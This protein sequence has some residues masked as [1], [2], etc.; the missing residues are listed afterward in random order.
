[1]NDLLDI[2]YIL[3][4][5]SLIAIGYL[6]LSI[7]IS[8]KEGVEGNINRRVKDTLITLS[9]SGCVILLVSLS[10]LLHAIFHIQQTEFLLITSIITLCI[11]I[12][13][14]N[15]RIILNLWREGHRPKFRKELVDCAFYIALLWI[16]FERLNIDIVS[17]SIPIVV[18]IVI[19]FYVII[20]TN[21]YARMVNL[22]VFPV[23]VYNFVTSFGIFTILS[24]IYSYRA[25]NR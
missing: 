24:G 23:S 11:V 25:C 19:L 13:Y 21:R 10:G 9:F 7:L 3:S 4:G 6:N 1:M 2:M 20:N 16:V 22:L 14:L 18:F 5:I 8:D 15:S 12:L 17:Y